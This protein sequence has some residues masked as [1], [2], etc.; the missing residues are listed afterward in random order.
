MAIK[1]QIGLENRQKTNF[2]FLAE[3]SWAAIK[4]LHLSLVWEWLLLVICS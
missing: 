3:L 1:F 4:L 2:I